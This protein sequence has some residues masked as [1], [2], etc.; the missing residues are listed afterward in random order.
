MHPRAGTGEAIEP[1][2][3]MQVDTAAVTSK[4]CIWFGSKHES[5]GR[6]IFPAVLKIKPEL[7]WQV[8]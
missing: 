1:D 5:L 7:H 6:H 8:L 4:S 2:W 3:Q